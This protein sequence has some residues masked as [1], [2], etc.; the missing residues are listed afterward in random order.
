[1]LKKYNIFPLLRVG[2]L[3][4]LMLW[5]APAAGMDIYVSPSGNDSSPCTKE[6]PC[7]TLNEA[8]LRVSGHNSTR[9]K[10][11]H[12]NYTMKKSHNFTRMATFGLFG[13]GSNPDNVTITCD[14]NAS[15][16]FTLSE[17][18]SFKGIKLLKCGGWFESSY[19]RKNYS[20]LRGAEFMAALD[21]RYCRNLSISDMEISSSPGLGANLYDVGGFVSFTNSTFAD[22]KAASS[23]ISEEGSELEILP[24]YVHSGGGVFVILNKYGDNTVNVTPSEHDSYQHNNHY[25]FIDCHF[26]R[27]EAR[28]SNVSENKDLNTPERPFSHGGG[29]A[30]F[31]K[32][33]AS[34]CNVG[35]SACKFIDNRASWGGGLQVLMEDKT[36]NNSFTMEETTFLRNNASFSGGAV[37]FGNMPLKCKHKRLILNQFIISNCSF[38]RNEALWGGG[39]SIFGRTIAHTKHP[40]PAVT[41][42]HFKQSTWQRNKANVGAAMGLYL[43]NCNEYHIGPQIPYHVCFDNG[44]VF[45]FNHADLQR[46]ELKIGQGTLYSLEVP[47]I[48]K[49]TTKFWNNSKSALVLD[50]ST[51]EVHDQLEFIN[52][53]GFRGGAIAMYGRS[54]IIFHEN[55]K[56]T[57][58]ANRCHDK[59]GAMY[60]QTPGSPLV[61]FNIH[62]CFFAYSNSSIHYDEWNITVIFKDNR[63]PHHASGMSVY[64]NTLK[65]CWQV[66]ENRKNNSVLRWKFVKFD[67]LPENF[68]NFSGEVATDPIEIKSVKTDWEVAPGEIFTATVKLYDEVKHLVPGIIDIAINSC[69]EV[70]LST[71]S[72]LFQTANGTITDI[73]LSG[74]EGSKFS[75]HLNYKGSQILSTVIEDLKLRNCHAGFSFSNGTCKCMN[76]VKDKQARGVSHCSPDGKDLYVKQGYW[77]GKV[78]GTFST[79]VCPDGYCESW[80][81]SA[82]DYLYNEDQVCRQG[83][84]Q[85]SILCGQCEANHS[86]TI[87]GERCKPECTNLYL[88]LLIPFALVLL[89]I[90]MGIMLIDLDVFTGYLNAW[91]YSYQVMRYLVPDGF[92]FNNFSEFVIALTNCQIKVGSNSF[93][94]V[95]GLDDADKL[96]VMY[97]IPVYVIVIVVLLAKMVSAFPNWCFSTRVKAPF[98][99]ICTILV[100]CYSDITY[101][102]LRILRFAKVGSRV[103]LY[104]NG[105]IEYFSGKHLCYGI[106]AILFVV[107]V[108]VLFPLFLLFPPLLTRG[109]RPV[110]NLNRWNPFFDALQSCF[111][112]QYRWCAAFYFICRLGLLVIYEFMPASLVKRLLLEVACILILLIFAILRPYKEARDVEEDEESYDWM[113]KSDVALLT[114]LSFIAV[115]SSPYENSLA[116]TLGEKDG[117]KIFLNILSCVPI[118]VL[119]VVLAFRVGRRYLPPC[120]EPPEDD[121][122]IMSE[123]PGSSRE[124]R[125]PLPTVSETTETSVTRHSSRGSRSLTDRSQASNFSMMA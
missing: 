95:K 54:R 63:A 101:I 97:L 91:V 65:N 44:T 52:N 68:T 105:E 4:M 57:F 78:N 12:G 31:F 109:F 74:K 2:S 113:N 32:G 103:V 118:A 83:R 46:G 88:L 117:L 64:V 29:L 60:I 73:S 50:G 36:E 69:S 22:N 24:R 96:M 98:R 43:Y 100:L 67:N 81:S 3:L 77:A 5:N 90:V 7:K 45:Q 26:L 115:A 75:V 6:K 23:D 18:I 99:G 9:I 20:D 80:D 72:T 48:F 14:A 89:L 25:L 28:W 13:P 114:T 30:L 38:V 61:R 93:C 124:G 37:R 1:M 108:S 79:F 106:V 121:L 82:K 49:S 107:F 110:L 39:A 70:Q 47:L 76:P 34:G 55:A 8:F 27:N 119:M 104:V 84:K 112:D 102:S 15:L 41:Q 71:T 120:R 116:I 94:L 16:S 56:S 21:F 85:G 92:L 125:S 123:T 19:G 66:G 33:N 111:K 86:V 53:T 40:A 122:P 59:G 87:G 35:I 62:T 11:E 17:N 42:F 10:L 51:L 58:E